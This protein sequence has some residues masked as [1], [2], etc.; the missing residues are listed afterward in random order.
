[1]NVFELEQLKENVAKEI[2]VAI[3]LKTKLYKLSDYILKVEQNSPQHL[4]SIFF[5]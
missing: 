3:L 5:E 4:K 1:M 2:S